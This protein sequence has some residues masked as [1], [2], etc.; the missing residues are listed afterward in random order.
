MYAVYSKSKPNMGREAL[1]TRE[2]GIISSKIALWNL[3]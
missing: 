2:S 1:S 3:S